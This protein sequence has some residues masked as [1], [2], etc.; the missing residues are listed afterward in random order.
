MRGAKSLAGDVRDLL[1]RVV[2]APGGFKLLCQGHLESVA[3]FFHAP[4]LLVDQARELLR[5]PKSRALVARALVE[6]RKDHRAH[7]HPH[8][9]PHP[10]HHVEKQVDALLRDVKACP[11]GVELLTEAALETA[12]LLFGAHPFVVQQARE[13]LVRDGLAPKGGGEQ[14][15]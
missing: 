1:A 9:A 12:A 11:G 5:D 15:G 2:E 7:P 14:T 3:S 4:V 13:R 8:E 10:P 6:A